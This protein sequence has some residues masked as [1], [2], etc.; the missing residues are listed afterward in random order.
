[1][2]RCNFFRQSILCRDSLRPADRLDPGAVRGM[3]FAARAG[4]DDAPVEGEPLRSVMEVLR[5]RLPDTIGFGELRAAVDA[6]PEA[7]SG[8]Q[9]EGFNAEL[10]MPHAAPLRAVPADASERPKASPL[11]RWQARQ[12]PELTSLAYTTV[13]MEE[14][15]ARL[16]ITLL[17]GTR[18]R[19]AIRAEFSE[20]TG[21]RLSA[22]DLDA[23]LVALGRLFLLSG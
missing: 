11:A 14:P 7:L 16:L 3:F 17:D 10:V 22:D 8:A 1:V 5:S 2:L 15:A 18:D 20:R 9:I 19:A 13:M 23:N 4:G 21:V 12:G 6:D